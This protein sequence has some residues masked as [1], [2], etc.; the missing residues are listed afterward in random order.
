VGELVFLQDELAEAEETGWACVQKKNDPTKEGY[1][2]FNYLRPVTKNTSTKLPAPV[3]VS[4]SAIKSPTSSPNVS[5]NVSKNT[6]SVE[7]L[8][9]VQKPSDHF[10][11]SEAQHP[12]L[13]FK[14]ADAKNSDVCFLMFYII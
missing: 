12:A 5:I 11:Q 2:P 9:N 6:P 13:D 7:Q 1:V 14:P 3:A 10:I 4:S 8:Q